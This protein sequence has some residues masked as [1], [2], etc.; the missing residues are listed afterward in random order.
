MDATVAATDSNPRIIRPSLYLPPLYPYIMPSSPFPNVPFAA[1]VPPVQRDPAR[2]PSSDETRLTRDSSAI[3]RLAASQWGIFDDN[4]SNVLTPDNIVAIGYSSEF[5]I[6]D[7]PLQAGNFESYDKVA[8]PSQNRVIATKG[9]TLSERQT[10]LSRLD[11]IRDDRKLY[12]VLTPE[13]AYF[14]VNVERVTLDRDAT[15]GAG[16]LTVEI[17]LREIRQTATAA[18][19]ASQTPSG[20]DEVNDGS[21]QPKA[22]S[23][24][25]QDIR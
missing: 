14:N 25:G 8:T 12:T 7:Y 3:D 24:S 23:Q 1:G 19:S 13:R 22:T 6:S 9:G 17:V 20:A 2:P 11:A 15:K 5:R 21:V 18:F 16:M 4:G 10:F